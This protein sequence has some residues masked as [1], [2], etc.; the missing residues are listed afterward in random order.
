M[1]LSNSPTIIG[2]VIIES[3]VVQGAR[4]RCVL[5]VQLSHCVLYNVQR[6]ELLQNCPV[7]TRNRIW[8]ATAAVNASMSPLCISGV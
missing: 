1:T 2:M 4:I 5:V 8:T 7:M 6:E 3:R